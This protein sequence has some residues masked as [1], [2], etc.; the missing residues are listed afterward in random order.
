[1]ILSS[2][3][4]RAVCTAVCALAVLLAVTATCEAQSSASDAPAA[5]APAAKPIDPKAWIAAAQ[6]LLIAAQTAEQIIDKVGKTIQ[7]TMLH[8]A[9]AAHGFDPLGL[10]AAMVVIGDQNEVIRQQNETIRGLMKSE[11]RQ[12][13]RENR[14]LKH[15]LRKV[16]GQPDDAHE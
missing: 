8:V 4:L 13:K 10:K 5:A 3:N 16:N 2:I 15:A 14:R 11:I 1:M 6:D 7:Q 12:L 9:Q